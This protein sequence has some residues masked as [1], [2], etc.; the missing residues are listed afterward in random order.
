MIKEQYRKEDYFLVFI[1]VVESAG[2][3]FIFPYSGILK[4]SGRLF[5]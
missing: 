1:Y 5:F 3:K 2:G 4:E